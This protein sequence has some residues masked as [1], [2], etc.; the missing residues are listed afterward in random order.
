ME[1]IRKA[2]DEWSYYPEEFERNQLII[3]FDE[4]KAFI[5]QS[6]ER[7]KDPSP[8]SEYLDDPNALVPTK[9]AN[10]SIKILEG[11]ENGRV[12]VMVTLQEL[13]ELE[14]QSVKKAKDTSPFVEFLDNP[15]ELVPTSEALWAQKILG[16]DDLVVAFE[17]RENDKE[18]MHSGSKLIR[19]AVDATKEN[20]CETDI[21]NQERQIA[22]QIKQIDEKN[23]HHPQEK[24]QEI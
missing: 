4:Y 7:E 22:T 18:L 5:E 14:E 6:K 11:I 24:N 12:K 1:T 2:N 21:T 15:N 17:A 10:F 23:N 19:D 8:F 9:E 13:H 3:S 20:V 16:R